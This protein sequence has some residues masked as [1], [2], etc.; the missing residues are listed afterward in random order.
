MGKAARSVV[1][2]ARALK[3]SEVSDR[4][5]E[6][7]GA[8]PGRGEPRNLG[9]EGTDREEALRQEMAARRAVEAQAK[10]L[11]SHLGEDRNTRREAEEA[12]QSQTAARQAAEVQV[13]ALERRLGK[14][15]EDA[16]SHP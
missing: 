14:L 1:E 7:L 3:A 11:E 6:V 8:K 12:L 15:Q 5:W 10:S 13:Q 2:K 16:E 9:T 4:I